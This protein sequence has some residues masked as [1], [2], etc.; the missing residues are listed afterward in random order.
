MT[1]RI[2]TRCNLRPR[3]MEHTPAMDPGRT[4]A[5]DYCA[6]CYEEM[7]YKLVELSEHVSRWMAPRVVDTLP[8]EMLFHP[9]HDLNGIRYS[10]RRWSR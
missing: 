1:V 2:C 5:A 4:W 6:D 9:D 7:G 3:A 8:D 10:S